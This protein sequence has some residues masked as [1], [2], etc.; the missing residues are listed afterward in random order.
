MFVGFLIPG[1]RFAVLN[2]FR[3]IVFMVNLVHEREVREVL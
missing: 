2:G 3:Y 1:S